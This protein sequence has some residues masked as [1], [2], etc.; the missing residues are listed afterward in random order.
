[1]TLKGALGP[2]GEKALEV[3]MYY[4][5]QNDAS[6]RAVWC[7][8]SLRKMSSD[9][10][11]DYKMRS[12]MY[13]YLAYK[14]L[15]H[16]NSLR[17]GVVGIVLIRE[18]E[19]PII[20]SR[21]RANLLRS[22]KMFKE[23]FPI[24]SASMQLVL[25]P[26]GGTILSTVF[27]NFFLRLYAG[28]FGEPQNIH[29]C[30]NNETR[31]QMFQKCEAAGISREGLSKILNGNEA[32]L[33]FLSRQRMEES[34]V[35]TSNPTKVTKSAIHE[36]QTALSNIE[37]INKGAY[38]EALGKAPDLAE[39]ESL[40]EGFLRFTNCDATKAASMLVK[41]W[42]MRKEVFGNRAFLPMNQTFEG[43]L[44]RKDV[45][46]LQT[47]Y[48]MQLP[49]VKSGDSVLYC[50]GTKLQKSSSTI[51]RARCKFYI[52]SI[53]SENAISQTRGFNLLYF[54]SDPS[55]D[56]AFKESFFEKILPVMPIRVQHV[57]ILGLNLGP[58]NADDLVEA[59]LNETKSIFDLR[60]TVGMSS[61]DT[62][63]GT[64][65]EDLLRGLVRHGFS[66]EGLPKAVCGAL[67]YDDFV[68]WQELRVRY[69]WGLF[70]N[71]REQEISSTYLIPRNKLILNE[72]ESEKSER[73]RRMT[74][75]LSRRKRERER[76][77]LEELQEEAMEHS[78]RHRKLKRQ[79]ETLHQLI[80]QANAIVKG[81]S[82]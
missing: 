9:P 28:F 59:R 53:M 37:N 31:E 71:S 54:S 44:E 42:E 1:M 55:F 81:K 73:K 63:I 77:A 27:V 70:T 35:V 14:V 6:G 74:I 52:L 25:N 49:C 4:L 3:G 7:A 58:A 68:K 34:R 36:M 5:H 43:A 79:N 20:D 8:E 24:K 22:G 48:M 64:S 56:R 12:K 75:I 45:A 33:E 30:T 51:S 13:Y 39:Q 21:W 38:L 60:R 41:Y 62:H 23:S 2:D 66:K 40:W 15:K 69:E 47:G 17:D 11:M 72:E 18:I 57:H 78:E 26:S 29:F 82:A 16:P 80:E 76:M 10:E 61:V 32:A 65:R 46:V 50:D 67:G 19:I